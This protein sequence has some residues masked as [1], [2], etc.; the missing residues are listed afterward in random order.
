MSFAVCGL[1]A[2]SLAAA[3]T[4]VLPAASEWQ[5]REFEDRCRASREFGDG[6][7]RTMLWIEQ[8]GLEP[9]YNLTLIGRPLRHPYGGGV[10]VQFGQQPEFIR[11]YIA[12]QSSKGRPVLTMYGVTVVQ[13]R[14]ERDEDSPA[15]D[16]GFEIGD[17]NDITTLDLRTSIV[18]PIRLKIGPMLEPLGVL[19]LCGAKISGILT[20]AGRPLTAEAKPPVPIDSDQWLTAADYPAYLVRSGM[21]GNIHIRLTVNREG[22]A[23]SCFVIE[24]NKPQLFDDAVCLGVLRRARFEPARNAK[25][26]PVPSYY[27]YAVSF[28][29]S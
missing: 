18:Q 13:P 14:L 4:L 12:A 23:S 29:V 25:G 22:R 1:A 6:E 27:S 10:H 26:E 17:A 15:P 19:G 7:D 20:D 16:L 24:S 21:E 3:E 2:T 9:I 28:T 11:S 8:G 5:Y